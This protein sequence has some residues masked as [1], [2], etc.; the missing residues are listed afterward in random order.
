MAAGRQSFDGATVGGTIATNDSGSL[1]HRHGTPRDLLIGVHLAMTDGRIV[2]A[3]G[4]VV[5]NVAGYDLGKL[6]SGSYGSLAAIVS[7]TFKLAPLPTSSRTL[8]ASFNQPDT[9][10]TAAL[11]IASSQLE[12]TCFD[13]HGVIGGPQRA[14]YDLV[15]CFASTREA[16]AAQLQQL[17]NLIAA[18]SLDELTGD[19]EADV[20]RDLRVRP[21]PVPAP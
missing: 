21:G 18:D 16:I 2:K 8:V 11:A 12:P 14:R 19:L 3:G 5:K 10:A 6:V 1:R 17:R 4:T 20:W 9:A 7:A 13:L 15:L